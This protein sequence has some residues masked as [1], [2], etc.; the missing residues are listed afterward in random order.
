MKTELANI[1]AKQITNLS[2]IFDCTF[3]IIKIKDG[4]SYLTPKLDMALRS[5][6]DSQIISSIR[7]FVNNEEPVLDYEKAVVAVIKRWY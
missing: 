1:R 4:I 5:S 6:I 2:R 3:D 7:C